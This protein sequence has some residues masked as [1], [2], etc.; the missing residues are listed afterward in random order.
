M[1][2][3]T[4][5]HNWAARERLRRVELLLWW[6]GW[7]GRAD[8]TKGFGIS[9]AQ[10]SGDI[11]RYVD[12]NPGALVY[13]TRRKRYEGTEGMRCVVHEPRLEEA[14]WLF[15]GEQVPGGWMLGSAGGVEEARRRVDVFR[16]LVRRATG[17]VERRVFLA[18]E[19]GRKLRVRYISLNSSR[20]E[21]REMAPHAMGHDGYRWHVRAWCFRHE[22]YRDF[23][24]SRIER[25]E[26]PG[27]G[28]EPPRQDEA[29]EQ[30]E[31]LVLVPHAGLDAEQRRSI[32][33]DYGMKDGRLVVEVRTAMRE[34]FLA[35]C[36]IPPEGED[37]KL[38]PQ[39]LDW[40]REG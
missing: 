28:F 11:Q 7:V 3:E 14:V 23:A 13:Q 26:W 30:M 19:Q 24:L 25:A 39:H 35:H 36:R 21:E 33:L 31:T 20:A 38:R 29:W 15:Y 12:M 8:L 18:M 40:L 16:P 17:E 34:Y 27:E 22:E 6:R 32:E 2:N 9:S 4:N 37:G 1:S 10:A 5:E